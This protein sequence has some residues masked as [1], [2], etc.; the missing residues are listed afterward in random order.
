MDMGGNVYE[1]CSDWYDETYYSRSPVE[2]PLGP[3][4]GTYWVLRG[5]GGSVIR[6]TC[7]LLP[8][9]VAIRGGSTMAP[10]GF[11]VCQE[12]LRWTIL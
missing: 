5:G 8:A 1:W 12:N 10:T 7:A 6:M 11:D 2:N 4:S 9:S 3:A